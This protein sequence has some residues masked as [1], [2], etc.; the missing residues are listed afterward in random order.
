VQYF[1]VC[2][3]PK[4]GTTWLQR[5][6]DEHPEVVCSGEGNFIRRLAVPLTEVKNTYNKHLA[7]VAD[8]VYEGK[9]YYSGLDNN[10]IMSLARSL[11]IQ[12]MQKRIKPGTKAIGDKTP[13]Y[14]DF[15][16]D[17]LLMFP[18][19]RFLHMVR[20]PRDVAVSL[21]HHA[22][23][24]G[25]AD[26]LTS[27]SQAQMR[28]LNSSAQDWVKAQDCFSRFSEAHPHQ[29]YGVR[30]EDFLCAPHRTLSAALFFLGVDS[31]PAVID[32]AVKGASFEKWSGRKPGHEDK[33]S[34]F[35]KGV[36][37]DWRSMLDPGAVEQITSVCRGWMD[38]HGYAL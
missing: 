12:L 8:R 36:A 28:L 27:R 35:R 1:F 30:Y 14:T 23:R 15:L 34:F 22:L 25:Y 29:C 37:G 11:I 4:S 17:L 24:F 2:G 31:S 9:P 38:R 7:V 6:L 32:H 20:D 10:E 3:A 19:A 5:L 21:L 16:N 33:L 13:R 18:E 26:A